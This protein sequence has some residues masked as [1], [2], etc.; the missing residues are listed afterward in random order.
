MA[1]CNGWYRGSNFALARKCADFLTWCNRRRRLY[2][3]NK[4][5]KGRDCPFGD[6]C[7]LRD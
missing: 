2:E 3:F 7:V 5:P 4:A 1:A 6:T